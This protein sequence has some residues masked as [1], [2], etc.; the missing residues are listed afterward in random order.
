MGVATVLQKTGTVWS[1][2]SGHISR[3]H[4][5]TTQALVEYKGPTLHTKRHSSFLLQQLF[6]SD[7]VG[8]LTCSNSYV[9]SLVWLQ[10]SQTADSCDKIEGQNFNTIYGVSVCCKS[11]GL[12]LLVS[13]CL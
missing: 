13:L 6:R 8:D 2:V 9:L 12:L 3:R 7:M 1:I 5:S 11:G 10:E 4:G